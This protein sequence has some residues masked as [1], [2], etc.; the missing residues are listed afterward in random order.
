M[1]S[2]EGGQ[3]VGL[4]RDV[5]EEQR[6]PIMLASCDVV[7]GTRKDNLDLHEIDTFAS[8]GTR[9][10]LDS[11]SATYLKNEKPEAS[12][13]V[14][15][16]S[17]PDN[18]TTPNAK[19][20]ATPA[21]HLTISFG[22]VQALPLNGVSWILTSLLLPPTCHDPYEW[23]LHPHSEPHCVPLFGTRQETT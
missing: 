22:T 9:Y 13:T 5:K 8:A 14:T 10:H 4:V 12:G 6:V 21:K 19:C 2:V 23:A 3:S 7:A 15:P 18:L 11:R 17:G 1:L 20:V 16:F